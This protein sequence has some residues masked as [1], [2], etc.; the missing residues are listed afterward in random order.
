MPFVSYVQ[1]KNYWNINSSNYLKQLL[2]IQFYDPCADFIF[3]RGPFESVQG[4][5]KILSVIYLYFFLVNISALLLGAFVMWLMQWDF[6]LIL[7]TIIIL[8]SFLAQPISN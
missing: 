5:L 4:R 2:S 1:L 8:A 6:N 3:D 7:S